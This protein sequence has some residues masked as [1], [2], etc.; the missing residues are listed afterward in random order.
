MRILYAL[1]EDKQGENSR[2]TQSLCE[3]ACR[4]RVHTQ[5][6]QR[7]PLGYIHTQHLRLQ[8]DSRC[9]VI[10]EPSEVSMPATKRNP[11]AHMR[12]R[13]GWGCEDDC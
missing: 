2:H 12:Q 11:F 10:P 6:T 9:G 13:P 4:L 1:K 3:T 8:P 7:T 5:H